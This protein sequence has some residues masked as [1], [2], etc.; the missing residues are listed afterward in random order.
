MCGG[1]LWFSA[2]R[3]RREETRKGDRGDAPPTSAPRPQV[4]AT[5]RGL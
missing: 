1:V 5:P 4:A 2:P 3:R